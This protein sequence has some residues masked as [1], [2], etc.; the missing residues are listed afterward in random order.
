MRL[1][2]LY[3]RSRTTGR[4]MA[5]L[6]GV[7]ALGWAWAAYIL[8]KPDFGTAQD[9]ALTAVLLL[10]PLTA[11]CVVGVGAHSPLGEAERTASYPLPALRL[12]HLGGLLLWG[13][14]V[15]SVAALGWDR[16]YVEWE[17]ARNLAGLSGMA[18]LAARFVGG[19]L[20]WPLPL[21]YGAL[22]LLMGRGESGEW[23]R[24][25]WVMHPPTGRL[26]A[27]LALGLLAAGLAVL[28]VQGPRESAGEAE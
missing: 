20:S 18:L 7:A 22:A 3:L 17:L 26:A 27:A 19:R 12:G 14:A 8:S 11:A 28:A 9:G 16:R 5:C 24:W 4:A 6:V 21:A 25:A 10:V 13:A 2:H 15:L 23:A 1:A